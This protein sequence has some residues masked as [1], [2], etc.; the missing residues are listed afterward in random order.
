MNVAFE[1][2]FNRI[3]K[4]E[5]GFSDHPLDKGGPTNLGITLK[6]L[7]TFRGKLQT[8]DDL[9]KLTLDDARLFY[10]NSFWDVMQL[11]QVKNPAMA[12]ILM[13]QAINR[14]IGPTVRNVQLAL[15]QKLV[16]L[17]A[18]DCILGPNTLSAL[19]SVD[20]KS[21]GVQ[22]VK[23]C[24]ESYVKIC[25]SNPD[26]NVFLMGWIRRTHALL[27]KILT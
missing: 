2:A 21:F 7:S 13:D 17:G 5:G 11:D 4:A 1:V 14:G 15:R 9:K 20:F 27:D 18:I 26:Q 10:K 23:E 19:N 8:V 16:Y 24:Q 3:M 25:Q 6:S 22:F 12:E